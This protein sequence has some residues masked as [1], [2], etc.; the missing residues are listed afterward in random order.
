MEY[1]VDWMGRY[2]KAFGWKKWTFILKSCEWLLESYR[3]KIDVFSA[4]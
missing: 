2:E 4:L 1:S 3:Q